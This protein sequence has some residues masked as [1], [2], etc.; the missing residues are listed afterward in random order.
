VKKN[1]RLFITDCEGPI[2]KNDNAFEITSKFI[3]KGELLFSQLSKYD[4]I[5]A[6]IVKRNG[7]NAGDT[8]K[9]IIPFLKAYGITSSQMRIYSSENILLM[10]G[11]KYTMSIIQDKMP[12]FIVSTSYN[13]YIQPLCEVLEFPFENTYCTKVDIDAYKVDEKEC[14]RIRHLREEICSMPPFKIHHSAKSIED[15]SDRDQQ[16][17]GR[18]DEIIWDEIAHMQL[19]VALYEVNPMGGF[20]KERAV[21]DIARKTGGKLRDVMYV[22]DSITDVE[23]FRLVKE[24]GGITISFNGN[25]FAVKEAEIAVLSENTLVTATLAQVFADQGR[26]STLKLID[27]R[28]QDS[29]EKLNSDLLSEN[30]IEKWHSKTSPE[31]SRIT[32]Q[33]VN[34]ISDKSTIFRKLVR[35]EKVGKLG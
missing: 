26:D 31:I 27:E 29:F 4:D 17:F 32:D 35:G 23:S 10:P 28:E 12:S 9:L 14:R 5:T 15:L 20:E 21:K 2:S 25:A 8:L 24:K 11:A 33:N 16:T 3:P 34:E 18:L 7:Y 6:G 22:G 1:Q 13:Q 19:G 30:K